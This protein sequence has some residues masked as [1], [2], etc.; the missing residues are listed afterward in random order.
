VSTMS[1]PL[2]NMKYTQ[3]VRQAKGLGIDD[4][5]VSRGEKKD[6]VI[7]K[8]HGIAKNKTRLNGEWAI[9]RKDEAAVATG[10]KTFLE[11]ARKDFFVRRGEGLTGDAFKDEKQDT[12]VKP[13]VAT[14]QPAEKK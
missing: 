13:I 10:I 12:D 8:Y 2:N 14:E 4:L 5:H 1:D 11:R 6:K 7:L 3:F 9:P